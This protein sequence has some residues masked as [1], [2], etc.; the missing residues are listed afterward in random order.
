MQTALIVRTILAFQLFATVI[1]MAG[2]IVPVM[3]G[4]AY[5]QYALYRNLNLASAY[6][7]LIMVM[8]MTITI[9]YLWLF[10]TK[11]EELGRG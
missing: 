4:E 11:E 9:L 6:A 5:F 8:S 7:V 3:A 10:R 2:R 1:V